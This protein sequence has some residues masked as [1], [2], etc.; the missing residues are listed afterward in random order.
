MT[1]MDC[2]TV[3]GTLASDYFSTSFH[4]A[5]YGILNAIEQPLLPGISTNLENQLGFCWTLAEIF[6]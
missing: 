5:D 2:C 3:G 4:S 6:K 1:V